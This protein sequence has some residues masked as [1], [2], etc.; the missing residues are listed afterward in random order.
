MYSLLHIWFLFGNNARVI[1]WENDNILILTYG[2]STSVWEKMNP[3][4]YTMHK[5]DNEVNCITLWKIFFKVIHTLH[6]TTQQFCVWSVDPWEFLKPFQ[7]FHKVKIFACK[8]LF[9]FLT[10]LTFALKA[11]LHLIKPRQWN[12]TVLVVARE[13]G[14]GRKEEKETISFS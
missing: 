1:Q 4:I 7:V 8:T 14:K 10:V 11:M 12:Q 5:I 6:C 9:I 2:I 3:S 13:G